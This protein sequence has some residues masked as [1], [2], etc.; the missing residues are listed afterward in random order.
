MVTEKASPALPASYSR[1][2]E[3]RAL[4]RLQEGPL[5]PF[6]LLYGEERFF[7]RRALE[8]LKQRFLVS[9]DLRELLYHVFHAADTNAED[10]LGLAKTMPFFDHPQL[11]V[12]HEADK[13]K[14][15]V[16]LQLLEYAEDPSPF[17]S[18]VLVAGDKLSKEKVPKE[19]PAR[20][21][22]AKGEPPKEKSPKV[23]LLAY[24]EKQWPGAC[25]GFPR[26]KK[27]QRGEWLRELAGE[28]GLGRYVNSGL[29]DQLT[30]VEQ[31]P[32]E[33]LVN[34]LEILSIHDQGGTPAPV[35]ETLANLLPEI[36]SHLGYLL[37]DAVLD[38]DE[39]LALERLHRFL[40]QGTP[41]LVLLARF[42]SPVRDVWRVKEALA[43]GER[44]EAILSESWSFKINRDRY[45]GLA[46]KIP[47][48]VLQ[49]MISALEEKDRLL[50]S[51]RLNPRLHLEELCGELVRGVRA[52]SGSS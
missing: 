22:S 37:A 43:M 2:L 47:W 30:E 26:L 4:N 48:P 29:F 44:L 20:V 46:R 10:L 42:V 45:L 15:P 33:I 52:G 34:Q 27:R 14:E 38:G 32:L 17:T 19:K 5:S 39:P 11:I 7:V 50:K 18:L 13:L 51:S 16:Q 31:V 12:V 41:P 40:D 6:I 49:G 8:I 9:E 1:H 23:G 21:K 36:P 35:D 3:G 28:K 24:V 25:F